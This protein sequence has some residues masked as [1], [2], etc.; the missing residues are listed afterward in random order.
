MDNDLQRKSKIAEGH[1]IMGNVTERVRGRK[2]V[3]AFVRTVGRW[4]Q[5]VQDLAP[6]GHRLAVWILAVL[7]RVRTDLNKHNEHESEG[8][9]PPDV[10]STFDESVNA[11]HFLDLLPK[12]DSRIILNKCGLS[13]GAAFDPFV[14]HGKKHD[15]DRRH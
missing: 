5:F 4:R 1:P 8:Q 7:D 11:L 15:L 3:V 14:N 13:F 10:R 2:S 12:S 6:G 9:Q